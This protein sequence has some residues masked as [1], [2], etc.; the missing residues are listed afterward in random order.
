MDMASKLRIY[1]Y[2]TSIATKSAPHNLIPYNVLYRRVGQG[3][4]CTEPNLP[5]HGA[6]RG[7][8]TSIFPVHLEP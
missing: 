4:K 5:G 1:I 7:N 3:K 8:F 6:E 2:T